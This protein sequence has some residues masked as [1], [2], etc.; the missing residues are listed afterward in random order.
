MNLPLAQ[1]T[2][3]ATTLSAGLPGESRRGKQLAAAA[4]V[5]LL[6]AL[7]AA[8][9]FVLQ[10]PDRN[11][12]PVTAVSLA[13][14]AP[15]ALGQ[16][17][18][19]AAQASK[20]PQNIEDQKK[21]ADEEGKKQDAAA[22]EAQKKAAETKDKT[23]KRATALQQPTAPAIVPAPLTPA[24][25]VTANPLTGPSRGS[26]APSHDGCLIVTVVDANNEPVGGAKVMLEQTGS[27]GRTGPKG[28][29]Q[30]C[31]L[32]PGQSIRVGVLGPRGAL[33]G[34]QTAV[35]ASRTFVTIRIPRAMEEIPQFIPNRK[36]PFQR[37]P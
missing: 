20:P 8:A 18:S 12:E 13:P 9:Y 17:S 2:V 14:A 15:A 3:A 25:P 4:V 28:H 36:R 11:R 34:S 26:T 27:R 32:T 1:P 29:W 24:P 31:G 21:A 37:R 22:I 30:E 16:E 23:D 19:S 5:V 7:A 33:L 10:R 35:V 6:L